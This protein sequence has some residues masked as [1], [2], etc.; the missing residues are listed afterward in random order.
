MMESDCAA[1]CG[2]CNRTE[3]IAAGP[4]TNPANLTVLLPAGYGNNTVVID[5][6]TTT[7][8]QTTFPIFQGATQINNAPVKQSNVSHD[9]P[10]KYGRGTV[11]LRGKRPVVPEQK[12]NDE[13]FGNSVFPE[14]STAE[15]DELPV[16]LVKT[17]I[18]GTCFDEYMYCREF[19]ALCV[20]PTFSYTMAKRCAL[21]CDRCEDVRMEEELITSKNCTDI[22]DNC[23]EHKHMCN[24]E[25]YKYLLEEKC[26]KTCGYCKP[27]C[28]DRHPNCRQ[29]KRDGFCVDGLYTVEERQYLCG[30]SCQM[31]N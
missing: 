30:D 19:V 29:F 7:A 22:F 13:L 2:F 14:I 6:P 17:V 3:S 31:C 4:V 5:R 27:A 15:P 21:T 28:R 23:D 18:K 1:T 25:R 16:S 12:T 10:P 11:P 20:H 24:A 26:A 9:E 8:N